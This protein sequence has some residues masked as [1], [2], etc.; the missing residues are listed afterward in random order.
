MTVGLAWVTYQSGRILRALP[1]SEN[2]LLAPVENMVKG[3]V[4]LLCIGLGALSGVPFK[5]LGW[6][7]DNVGRDVGLGLILG[8]ATQL[9]A[10]GATTLAIKVWGKQIYSP[11]VMKNIMPRTRPEWLLVP[12]ALG[13]AV[14]LEELLFRSLLLGGLGSTV[15]IPLLVVGFSAIFGLMHSPQGALGVVLTAILGMWLCLLFLW[16]GGL[17]LPLTVHYVINFLQL[18]KAQDEQAWLDS[19]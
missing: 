19:Y 4:V 8:L 18:L 3:I 13:L 5:Q 17:L 7:L 9:V 14:L 6:T 2:L 11:V 12:A 10:N 16:S 15:P 1:V